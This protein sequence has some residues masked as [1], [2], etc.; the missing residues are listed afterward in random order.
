V[1]TGLSGCLA[2]CRQIPLGLEERIIQTEKGITG[3]DHVSL[4]GKHLR[5]PAREF[6]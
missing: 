6:R 5:H 2:G 1:P 3:G 4:F